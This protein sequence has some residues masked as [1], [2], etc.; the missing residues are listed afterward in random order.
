MNLKIRTLEEN[1]IRD[2]NESGLPIEAARYVLLH[3]LTL[4]EAEAAKAIEQELQNQQAPI[5][6][7][8]SHA[9]A[10]SARPEQE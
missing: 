4:V 6:G 10:E 3:I 8:E 9:N 5:E 1:L 7:D 2:L